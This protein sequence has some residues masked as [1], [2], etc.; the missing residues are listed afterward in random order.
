MGYEYYKVDLELE[1]ISII[2]SLKQFIRQHPNIIYQNI[3]VGGSDFEFDCELQTQEE[4]YKLMDEI[5]KSFPEKIRHYFYYKAIKIY[6][7]S[8]FPDII[9]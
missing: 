6:K 5:K 8:Y 4:F 1:D 9:T 3:T 2:P 7:Y